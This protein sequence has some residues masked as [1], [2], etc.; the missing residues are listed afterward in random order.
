[1]ISRHFDRRAR[2]ETMLSVAERLGMP[3]MNAAL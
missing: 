2:L 1:M 3:P